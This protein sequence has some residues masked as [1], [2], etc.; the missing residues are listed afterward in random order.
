[1][2]RY[3]RY[4]VPSIFT[5]LSAD[6]LVANLV[7]LTDIYLTAVQVLSVLNNPIVGLGVVG[8]DY[9]HTN[10]LTA[11]TVQTP[12]GDSNFWNTSYTIA[13][14]V[15][16]RLDEIPEILPTVTNYLSTDFVTIY[17]LDIIENLDVA[18]EILS[19]GT[20][21]HDIFITEETDNQTLYYDESAYELTITNGN[22]VN[23]SSI[24]TTFSQNSSKYEDLYTFIETTS[25]SWDETQQLLP[26]VVNYL[27]TSHV[28][29]S[30]LVV[31]E[32]KVTTPGSDNIVFTDNDSGKVFHIDTTL[33]PEVTAN[34]SVTLNDGF[35][36][37]LVNTGTGII[38]VRSNFLTPFNARGDFNSTQH[39]GMF[40]YKTNEQLFGIGVFE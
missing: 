1:M 40:I 10:T 14:G 26:T 19:G 39:T 25:G 31:P 23:L 21:L 9:V 29:I 27:S 37:S 4:T 36:V 13:T 34:F 33:N 2:S 24:N 5:S 18:Q 30:S 3:D 6:N 8:I 16:A 15:S 20:P 28:Q 32:L 7:N 17:G 22:T 35:N 38:Y 12:A 11:V